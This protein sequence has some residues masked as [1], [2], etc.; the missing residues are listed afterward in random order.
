[1]HKFTLSLIVS[2]LFLTACTMQ[3]STIEPGP[4]IPTSSPAGVSETQVNSQP[5]ETPSV[6]AQ[7]TALPQTSTASELLYFWPAALPSEM[8][9]EAARSSA[10]DNGYVI[11]F[12]NPGMGASMDLRAGA[13]ADRYPYCGGRTNPYQIRGVQG[14]SSMGTGAG[15]ALE[16]KENGVHYSVGGIGNSLEAVVQFAGNLEVLDH[17]AWQQKFENAA[18]TSP[19]RT[20]IEFIAGATSNTSAYRELAGGNSDEYILGAIA[21]QELT[22]N[23]APYTFAD[24]QNFVLNIFGTDGSVLVSE[25][26]RTQVWTGILPATQDYVIRV[27][28]QGS[29]AQYRLKVSIPWR[30]EFS[31]G[32]SSATLEGKLVTGQESNV[33]LLQARAGQTMTVTSTSTNNN[34]CLSIAARMTDGSYVPLLNSNSQPATA[35]SGTL[36]TGAGYSQDYSISVSLCP[37]APAADTPYTL[38]I[39]VVN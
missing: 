22:V 35:W 26:A 12:T 25:T 24:S 3:I 38:F 30:I 14:C 5:T 9:F 16:W 13:E 17:Q 31:A 23:V 18:T 27:T 36:P 19:A 11:K 34:I 21:G 7:P 32:S 37:D 8:H 33:Y 10:G 39:D 4:V 6:L 1:M 2:V 29:A 28:N 20:R 15:A